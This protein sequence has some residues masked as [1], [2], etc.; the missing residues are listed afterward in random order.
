MRQGS[1]RFLRSPTYRTFWSQ[2]RLP[3]H[4]RFNRYDVLHSLD[5]KLPR[6]QSCATV[7]TLYDLGFLKFPDSAEKFHRERFL[8]FTRDAVR[9]ATRLIAISQSTKDD[10][11]E[12]FSVPAENVDVVYLGVDKRVYHENVSPVTRSRPY[13]LSVG[14]L[15]PRKNY[16]TL[17]EAFRRFC[18]LCTEPI[19]LVVVGQRGWLWEGIVR[20]ARYGRYADRIHL[21]GYI[22]DEAMPGFY[23]GALM[24]VMPSLYEGFG[25]P[26]L[27]AMACG[28]PVICSCVSSLPEVVG[29]AGVLINPMEEDS[30]TEAMLLLLQSSQHRDEL[31]FRGLQR[32]K[33]FSWERTAAATLEVYAKTAR[34]DRQM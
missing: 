18:D 7:V 5:H 32:A 11:C 15:Q 14:T 28:T 29:G 16:A 34:K 2:A 33:E 10:I 25:I 3:M 23:S 22:P 1:V 24:L 30:W 19:D 31:R 21:L 8:W 20:D 6:V 4:L 17:F 27:E 9:R 12:Y 13:I 26:V